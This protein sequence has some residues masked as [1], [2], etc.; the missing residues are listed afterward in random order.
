M[1][2]ESSMQVEEPM[3]VLETSKQ[4]C[5][6]AD[7][8]V[9]VEAASREPATSTI[10]SGAKDIV[11]PMT[12]FVKPGKPKK[13]L[14]AFWIYSNAVRESVSQELKEKGEH[15]RI[16]DLAKI[17]GQRWKDLPDGERK[18][19]DD[20]A[21]AERNRYDT[22]MQA[23]K[24]ACDPTAS[25]GQKHQ[26]LIPQRPLNPQGLFSK[27]DKHRSTALEAL[28]AEGKVTGEKQV[29]SKLSEMWKDLTPDG[30]IAYYVEHTKLQLEFLSLQNAW[31]ATPEFKELEEAEKAQQ[32]VRKS[33]EAAVV[34]AEARQKEEEERAKK[35]ARQVGQKAHETPPKKARGGQE[36]T[37]PPGAKKSQDV[38]SIHIEE[39]VLKEASKLGLASALE[40][41]AGRPEIVSSRKSARAV[42]DALKASSGLVNPA[43]R[44][45]LG[46]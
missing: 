46:L 8:H 27:D 7:A 14:N 28:Q 6:P 17:I 10:S 3:P 1:A 37:P 5:Q 36:R 30:R 18:V 4:G 20:K 16:S 2:A 19:Y 11:V 40:N 24:E 9:Q 41:L 23:Y 33:V 29:L 45:L 31:Q 44:A 12:A 15:P 38:V 43:K 26:H 32:E 42:L 21:A 25:L 13:F 22:E 35:R 34:A 39:K